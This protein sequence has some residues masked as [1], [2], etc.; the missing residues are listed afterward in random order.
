ME[1]SFERLTYLY[2]KKQS[3][4]SN[5][6]SREKKQVENKILLCL[7][8]TDSEYTENRKNK[9]RLFDSHVTP[10]LYIYYAFLFMFTFF[11][12]PLTHRI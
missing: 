3:V 11:F 4:H 2:K 5:S 8:N 7:T 12:L 9:F 1:L 6:L 10:T